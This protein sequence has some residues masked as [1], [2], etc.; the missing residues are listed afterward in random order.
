[1]KESNY[2][3]LSK[4][5]NEKGIEL[6]NRVRKAG[7]EGVMAKALNS[8]YVQGRSKYWLKIK[9]LSTI[10][11]VVLGFTSTDK[12]QLSALFLG[13]YSEG[14][15]VYIG[16]VG[17]GFGE[18]ERAELLSKLSKMKSSKPYAEISSNEI[19]NATVTYAKPELVAEVRFMEM[20]K[21]HM[22]RAPSFLRLRNDKLPDDCTIESAKAVSAEESF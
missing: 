4:Y 11:A 6:F 12:E 16:K 15:L 20:T 2:A 8:P 9:A 7:L 17:T 1:M 22:L 14:K 19:G 13:A 3:I 21:D 10:D 18:A 5:I